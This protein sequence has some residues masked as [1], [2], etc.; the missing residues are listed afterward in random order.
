[1]NARILIVEDHPIYREG[2]ATYI[3]AEPDLEVCEQAEDVAGALAG[4]EQCHPDLVILDLQ[5][6]QSSGFD[7]LQD[8]RHRWPDLAVLV[9]T[10]YDEIR[11]AERLLRSGASGFVM[12]DKGPETVLKAIR[13]VLQGQPYVSDH[14]VRHVLSGE[15][16]HAPEEVLTDRELQVFQLIGEGKTIEEVAE[17]LARSPKTIG[18]HVDSVRRKLKVRSRQE[19][20]QV[21]NEWVIR[22]GR[23]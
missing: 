20:Y 19:L 18:N 1:M 15:A 16:S 10:M 14:V 9:L 21:A 6:K 23:F 3:N 8:I 17:M 13:S 7:L 22:P 5:L 12:K 11:Y 4:I 2:L